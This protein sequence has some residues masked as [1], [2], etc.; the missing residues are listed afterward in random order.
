ML[1]KKRFIWTASILLAVA[2]GGI[3]VLPSVLGM[4]KSELSVDNVAFKKVELTTHVLTLSGSLTSSGMSYRD[5]EYKQD[6]S[7]LYVTLQGGLVNK[8]HPDGDFDISI[9]NDDF[10]K[11]DRVYLKYGESHTLIFP[12][13]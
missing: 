8:K 11:V 2:L 4:G 3:L 7:N 1:K 5:C 6:G 12:Q 10:S 13:S 9:R